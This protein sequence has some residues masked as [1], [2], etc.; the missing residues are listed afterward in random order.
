LLPIDKELE[1]PVLRIKEGDEQ[2]KYQCETFL[3]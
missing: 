3:S 1:A 2:Y